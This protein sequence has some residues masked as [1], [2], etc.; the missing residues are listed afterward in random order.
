VEAESTALGAAL[1]ALR[2][3][4][5]AQ[6]AVGPREQREI[7]KAHLAFLDD[8]ELTQAAR[9]AIASGAS[10]GVAWRDAIRAQVAALRGVDD[11]LIAQRAD[12]LIDLE[13]QLLIELSG[14]AEP[15]QILPAG[16]ILL[17][18]DLGPG[19]LM[20][21]GGGLAG[22]CTAGGGPTSHVAILAN[23]LNIP[24]VVAM[25]PALKAVPEGAGL[26]LDGGA[27]QLKVRPDAAEIEATQTRLAERQARL[28]RSRAEAAEPCR[29]ADGTRIEVFANLGSEADAIAAMA[30][31]AEGCGLLRTEFLFMERAEAPDEDEQAR[32]YQAIATALGGLPLVIRTLDI[33]GDK[34]APYLDLPAEENPA[35]GLR[36]VR[37]SLW[38]P[39]LLETQLRAI[40]SVRTR[41]QCRILVP[42]VAS[43]AELRAVW[44]MADAARARTGHDQPIQIGVMVETPAAAVTADILAAEADFLSIGTND[45]TQYG[46]A[47][48]RGNPEVASGVD[49]LHP[50]VLRLIASTTRG[51]RVHG[52]QVAVCGGLAADVH[53]AAILV[54][55]G[56]TE[57][58]AP[59]GAIPEIKAAVR[60]L[61][62]A[63]CEALA[64][65]A[66]GCASAA[67]VRALAAKELGGV[68]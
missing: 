33:G 32:C 4:I 55:L 34:P 12:D 49:A 23:A 57:L 37:V 68:A 18:D 1:E 8:E 21:L 61:T 9:R 67:E 48:D 13:R 47:M 11:P 26:I 52:R 56:V 24:A 10:A 53:G 51:A 19:Q 22:V 35:L 45:L 29:M 39:Q 41:G 16:A 31:G 59:P 50:A 2:T 7:V 58:S 15:Q 54:G 60:A 14:E 62:L 3:R 65:R 43:L 5:T 25:G 27:G 63:A 46:L 42:M 38:K 40:L 28:A 17:A 30:N 64:R 44:T 20:G 66:L 6:A 36:G